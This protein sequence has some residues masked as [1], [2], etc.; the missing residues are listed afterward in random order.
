MNRHVDEIA[1][2]LSLRQPQ[3]RSLEI[4][5][6]ITDRLPLDKGMDLT[7]AL[8]AARDAFPDFSGFD[9]RDFPSFCFALATG[10]GKTR[11]MGAF[12][13][14]LHRVHGVRNFLILA[15]GLTVYEK[16]ITDFTPGTAKY[17]LKGIHEFAVLPPMLVTGEILKG[18]LRA[19]IPSFR[20][21]SIFS[22]S[23]NSRAR[24]CRIFAKSL[25]KAISRYCRGSAISCCSWMSRIVTGQS[26]APAL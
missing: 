16:L 3:R 14:Y 22:T 23:T 2:R 15:P 12:V 18:L 10:V 7:T 9:S 21:G 5:A 26:S 4:L 13:A 11:L 8:E 25:A 24:V 19:E 1:A 20:Y 17:V 6:E